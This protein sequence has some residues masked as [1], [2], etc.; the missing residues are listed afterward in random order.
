MHRNPRTQI[1]KKVQNTLRAC[2]C[3]VRERR[4]SVCVSVCVRPLSSS[5]TA[6]SFR[7]FAREF[8][9]FPT[10]GRRTRTRRSRDGSAEVGESVHHTHTHTAQRDCGCVVV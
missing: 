9:A 4:L 1:H 6:Q 7:E 10:F 2:V 3:A 5:L 8:E